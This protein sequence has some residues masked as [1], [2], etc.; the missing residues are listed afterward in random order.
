M[1][2]RRTRKEVDRFQAESDDGDVYTV[3]VFQE[4]IEFR[5]M[6]G[7]DWKPGLRE[8][9]LLDGSHVN[10]IDSETFQILDTDEIIRKI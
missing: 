4:F 7:N 8:L 9:K 2:G 10:E 3:V 6:T 1:A 5:S